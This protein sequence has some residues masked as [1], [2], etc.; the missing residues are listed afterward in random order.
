M[1][2]D[3]VDGFSR[4]ARPQAI[5]VS[6]GFLHMS[7]VNDGHFTCFNEGQIRHFYTVCNGHILGLLT[8]DLLYV[9]EILVHNRICVT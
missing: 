7:M 4:T 3:I 9:V 1:A 8:Y 2:K 6:V 5:Y